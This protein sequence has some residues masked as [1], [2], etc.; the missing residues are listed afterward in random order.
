MATFKSEFQD[1]AAEL[2][3]DEFSDFRRPLVFTVTTA[4]TF[5]PVTGQT[6]GG[7]VNTYNYQ[8]IPSAMDIEQ[9]QGFDVAVTDVPVTYRRFDSF[10]PSVEQQCVFAGKDFQVIA[11]LYD[12]ADATVK[13]VLRAL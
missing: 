13:L 4:G 10:Q 6:T 8:A 7:T 11:A 5:N 3:D 1:L 2:I 9:W 12:A